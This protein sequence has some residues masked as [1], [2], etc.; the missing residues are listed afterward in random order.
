MNSLST[1][2]GETA[3][4]LSIAKRVFAGLVL[5]VA[6]GGLAGC[7]AF[8]P[9]AP[10]AVVMERAQ[11]RWNAL[12]AGEIKTA[13]EY[14]SPGSRSLMTA[15]QYEGTLRKGFWKTAKVE[16]VECATQDSCF[17]HVSIEYEFQGRRTKTPLGE[18]WIREGSN[19]WYVQK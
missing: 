4:F 16:K 6:V 19:W 9:Q 7:A 18:T 10:E 2:H 12:V 3:V 15:Q 1:H 5:G 8:K 11:A 17:V 13:Y 14:F